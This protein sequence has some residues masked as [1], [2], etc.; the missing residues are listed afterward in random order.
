[1][2]TETIDMTPSWGEIG[3]LY[4]RLAESQEVKAIRGMRADVARAFAAAQ[5][6]QAIKATLTEEQRALVASTLAAEL[7]K[8]GY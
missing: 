1:M 4:V 6:L 8:Q 5:A 2:A 3:T 7:A